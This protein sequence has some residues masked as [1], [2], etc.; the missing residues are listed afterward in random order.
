MPPKIV[1]VGV[2]AHTQNAAGSAG[3]REGMGLRVRY[4]VGT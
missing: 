4:G 1:I 3:K 2:R